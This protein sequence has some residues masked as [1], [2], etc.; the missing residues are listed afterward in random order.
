MRDAKTSD[1]G[2]QYEGMYYVDTNG[3]DPAVGRKREL[4]AAN[5]PEL[6]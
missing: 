5:E 1:E 2:A 3:V 4:F 6:R